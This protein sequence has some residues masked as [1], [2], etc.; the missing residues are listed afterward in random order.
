MLG[1]FA[2]TVSLSSQSKQQ[3]HNVLRQI[4]SLEQL[5][6]MSEAVVKKFIPKTEVWKVLLD[7]V[8][9]TIVM[10]LIVTIIWAVRLNKED[11]R[12]LKKVEKSESEKVT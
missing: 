2:K 8:V 5:K 11:S 3:V 6:I 9:F 7:V 1:D 10:T 12:K 4:K